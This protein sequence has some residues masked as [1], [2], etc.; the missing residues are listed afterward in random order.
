MQKAADE[1]RNGTVSYKEASEKYDVPKT[2]LFRCVQGKSHTG[3]RGPITTVLN[4]Q[5]ESELVSLILK[6]QVMMYGLTPTNIRKLAYDFVIRNNIPHP[7]SNEKKIAGYDWFYGFLDR[8]KELS[9]RTAEKTSMAR[10]A[11]FNRIQVSKFFLLLA[12]VMS[13]HRFSPENIFNVDESGLSTVPNGSTKIVS[14]KGMKQVGIISSGEKG[15][16][17]TVVCCYNASGTM[18]VPPAMIFKRKYLYNHLLRN[19]PKGT[20]GMTSTNGWITNELF[21]QWLRHFVDHTR[22]SE[23]RKILLIMDNHPSHCTVDAIEMARNNNIILLTIPPHSSHKLQ[24]LDKTFFSALKSSY[25]KQC[26]NFLINN[27]GKR[28]TQYEIAEL[29]ASSYKQSCSMEKAVK[30]FESCGI[31]PYNDNI[32]SDEDFAPSNVT[33]RI[34]GENINCILIKTI[35]TH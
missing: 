27:P 4:K 20:L 9:V 35:D 25:A 14:K 7:F 6:L 15:E 3:Q 23:S 30:G 1:I 18:F 33:E 5:Q 29:F 21:V 26:T 32:F 11:G 13:A 34:S 12:E 8:H 16:T 17:T 31:F 19:A 2:T 24:P 10:L 28:I 22:P